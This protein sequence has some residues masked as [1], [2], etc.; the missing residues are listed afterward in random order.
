MP[1]RRRRRGAHPKD[2]QCFAPEALETLRRA[3]GDLCWLRSRGYPDKA[4]LKLVGDRY[5]LRLRQRKALQHCAVDDDAIRRRRAGQVEPETVRGEV[6]LIDGYN[7]LLTVEAALGGGVVL[8]ARDGVYRDMAAM[9]SHFRR[10]DQTRPALELIGARLDA[11]GCHRAL[12]YLDRPISNSGR[13]KATMLEVADEHGWSWT[14]ELVPN[15]DKVL[16]VADEI[17]ATADGGILD[18]GPRWLNLARMIVEESVP[19]AWVV[20]L[21]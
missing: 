20:D 9:T 1:D 17:V 18:K 21:G 3:T 15:P 11:L 10:V 8:A 13:L 14:V 7:V 2:R 5:A 6:L 12:W 16:E 4:S 19:S